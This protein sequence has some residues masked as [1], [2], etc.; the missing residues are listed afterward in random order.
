[1]ALPNRSVRIDPAYVGIL[2]AVLELL[3]AGRADAVQCALD[4]VTSGAAVQSVGPFRDAGAALD[5]L[6][7]RMVYASHPQALWLFGSRARGQGGADS[8]FDFLAVFPDD[9]PVSLDTRRDQLAEAV[10]GAGVGVDIAV[11]RASDMEDFAAEA[12]SLIRSVREEGREVYVSR[13]ERRR[14]EAGR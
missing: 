13:P 11:C 14:R 2:N 1:M 4:A 5:F 3:R 12:G 6:V 9:D 7:G 8:D 10:I